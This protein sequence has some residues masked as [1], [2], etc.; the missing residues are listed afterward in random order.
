MGHLLVK[1]TAKSLQLRAIPNPSVKRLVKCLELEYT[2][3]HS[4]P[5]MSVDIL[6]YKV[7]ERY[8]FNDM[9]QM[10]YYFELDLLKQKAYE[11]YGEGHPRRVK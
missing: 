5:S 1:L 10:A 11:V 8:R 7:V 4:N 3:D 2:Y 9:L 6:L